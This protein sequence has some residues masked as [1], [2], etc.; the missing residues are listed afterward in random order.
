MAVVGFAAGL[1]TWVWVLAPAVGLGT[2]L[3]AIAV[4]ALPTAVAAGES[5]AALNSAILLTVGTLISFAGPFVAGIIIDRS[6]LLQAGF[7]PAV[8]SSVTMLGLIALLIHASGGISAPQLA[9][10]RQTERG[11]VP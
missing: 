4:L 8:V 3:I 10:R 2:G 7:V 9:D 6:G 11:L 1:D 5:D